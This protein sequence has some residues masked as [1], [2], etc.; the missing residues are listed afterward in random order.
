MRCTPVSRRL[1]IS[2]VSLTQDHRRAAARFSDAGA[3]EK[4]VSVAGDEDCSS[5]PAQIPA[6]AANAPSLHI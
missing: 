5:S 6:C 4:T 1:N 2:I 3:G